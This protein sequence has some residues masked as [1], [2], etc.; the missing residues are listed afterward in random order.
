MIDKI[1]ET[2]NIIEQRPAYTKKIMPFVD[3]DI[4]YLF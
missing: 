2:K 1:I 3:K 4:A